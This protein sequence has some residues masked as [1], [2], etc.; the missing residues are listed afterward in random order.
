MRDE[1]E[2]SLFPSFY[3]KANSYFSGFFQQFKLTEQRE[4]SNLLYY[5]KASVVLR[6]HLWKRKKNSRGK[7]RVRL[8]NEVSTQG[9]QTALVLDVVQRALVPAIARVRRDLVS[10]NAKWELQRSQL[11]L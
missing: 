10:V 1:F 6:G 5:W 7:A 11:L 8:I 2:R 3:F 4:N 9:F